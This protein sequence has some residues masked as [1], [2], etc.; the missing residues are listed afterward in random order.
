ME[1]GL[2]DETKYFPSQPNTLH[3]L[4]KLPSLHIDRV[5]GGQVVARGWLLQETPFMIQ[6]L[7]MP[8]ALV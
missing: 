7:Q 1:Q 4:H 2:I 6:Y 3:S 5:K 8:K